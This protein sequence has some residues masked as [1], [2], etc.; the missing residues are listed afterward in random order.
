[1]GWLSELKPEDDGKDRQRPKRLRPRERVRERAP[2]LVILVTFSFDEGIYEGDAFEKMTEIA[3]A[4]ERLMR[5]N[6]G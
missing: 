2:G 3:V 6:R 5:E 1:M 4:A